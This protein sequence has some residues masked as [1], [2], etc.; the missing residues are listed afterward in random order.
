MA[1]KSR[2]GTE[3]VSFTSM[4]SNNNEEAGLEQDNDNMRTIITYFLIGNSLILLQGYISTFRPGK[5]VDS[6]FVPYIFRSEMMSG[7]PKKESHKVHFAQSACLKVE[8]S[9]SVGIELS[10]NGK[11]V[12]MYL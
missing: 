7:R 10:K 8:A 11:F 9:F 2:V 5:M 4:Q 6:D 1:K 12:P 3:P